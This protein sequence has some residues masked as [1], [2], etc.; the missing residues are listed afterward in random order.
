MGETG[1]P[2]PLPDEVSRPF[3]EG[4]KR[5]ELRMQRCAACQ[6]MRFT[7]RVLC[8]H[9][10]SAESEWVPVSGRGTIYSRVVCHP[11]VLPAFAPRVPYAVVLVELDEDP[12]LRLVGNVLGSPAEAV[13]IGQRVEVTFED[14]SDEIALPQWRLAR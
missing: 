7:P 8:P 10:H 5:R 12:G 11:P 9:C 3:W 6:R 4:C 1:V 13:R 2:L 14:V